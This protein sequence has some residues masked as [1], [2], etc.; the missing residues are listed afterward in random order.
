M[1]LTS[2]RKIIHV[3]I[4]IEIGEIREGILIIGN[5]LQQRNNLP[6]LFTLARHSTPFEVPQEEMHNFLDEYCQINM[7]KARHGENN[8]YYDKCLLIYY[9]N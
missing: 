3:N 2:C 8:Y 5:K 7:A 1:K 4:V 9:D 6:S